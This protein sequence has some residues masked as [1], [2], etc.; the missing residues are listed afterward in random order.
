MVARDK[1]E[2]PTGG[3]DLDQPTGANPLFRDLDQAQTVSVL[4]G[5]LV[6]PF[7]RGVGPSYRGGKFTVKTKVVSQEG[8]VQIQVTDSGEHADQLMVAFRECQEGRCS[9]PTQEYEKVESLSVEQSDEGIT[10]SVKSKKGQQ[11]D[12]GEVEKCLEHT[13]QRIE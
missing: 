1:I 11:I 9:C 4:L 12:I 10:L 7:S 2:L 6:I 5:C 13:K 3:L 8:G